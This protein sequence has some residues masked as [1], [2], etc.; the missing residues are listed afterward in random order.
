LENR[1]T[2]ENV[3]LY[4]KENRGFRG[5]RGYAGNITRRWRFV[6]G[7]A[8][9]RKPQLF[10][11]MSLNRIGI[12][13]AGS[14]GTA[15][16]ILLAEKRGPI[17]LWGHDAAHVEAMQMSRANEK[18]L[19]GVALPAGINPTISLDDIRDADLVL[20]V[21][22]SKAIRDVARRFAASPPP[23]DAVLLSCTKGIEQGSGLRMSEILR[24]F[25]PRNP[26]AVLS[27][28][29]H[30][31]EVARGMPTAVVLGCEVEAVARELQQIFPTKRFRAYT[32]AD[33][34]GIEL[35]GALKN[36]F[37]IAAGVSDGVGLGDNSKAGLV[38]RSLAEL[39]RLGV[40]L[41]GRRETFQGLSGIGDLIVTCFSRHSR[42]RRFGERLGGGESVADIL[43]S[44]TMVAEGVPTALS[45]W[46]CA[47]KLG[48]NAPI[49]EQVHAAL[50]EGKP[51]RV[52]MME[53]LSREP[54]PEEDSM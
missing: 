37:A 53:L 17:A 2:N 40:A 38:T 7:V 52:A 24:E 36:I 45:A 34:A 19:P 15:L 1:N 50:Y 18:Y 46:E 49:I 8:A 32:S 16:G 22:P 3:G 6:C 23:P 9:R 20:F 41:G 27:G 26:I 43:R 14:W 44:M 31:E 21:T 13:G 30:A 47:Q 35:G 11:P 51:A 48:V 12:I 4:R 42:N 25:F 28:P 10:F 39:V 54:R 5:W 33:V 29:T